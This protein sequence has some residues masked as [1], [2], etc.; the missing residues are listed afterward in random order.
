MNLED[1][2]NMTN[3]DNDPFL[4]GLS[5]E[6]AAFLEVET[7]SFVNTVDYESVLEDA[8]RSD[9]RLALDDAEN[10]TREAANGLEDIGREIDESA[11]Y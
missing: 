2:D 11:R 10:V 3:F 9:L 7:R 8:A 4:P 6:T 5:E 1:N